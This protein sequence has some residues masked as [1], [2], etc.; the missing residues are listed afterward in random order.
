M[1]E[2][3]LHRHVEISDSQGAVAAAD[4]TISHESDRTARASLRATAGHLTPGIRASLV[5]AVLDLPEVQDSARLEAALPLG[6]SE[7]LYRL[8]QR[9][10]DV[11]THPAGTTALVEASLGAGPAPRHGARASL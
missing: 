8:R 11:R 6:D 4:V 10:Q 1:G 5:D 3:D 9:C 7:T 2:H